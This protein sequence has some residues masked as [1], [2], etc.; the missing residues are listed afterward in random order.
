M[1]QLRAASAFWVLCAA[2]LAFAAAP[3]AATSAAT[4]VVSTSAV[5]NGSGNPD[6]E[7]TTGWFR[8]STISPG[9]CNDTFGT[10]VPATSGTG[11][12]TG[13]ATVTYAITASSLTAGTTY[14]FCAIT[15]NGSG[16]AFG[17][18][19]SFTTPGAP[20]V[21]TTGATNIS[22]TNAQL[23]GSANPTAAT[24]TGWF[25][26]ATTD[27]GPAT[28]P[29]GRACRPAAPPTP[30]WGAEAHRSPTPST[31]TPSSG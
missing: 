2:R 5:L 15:S 18:V 24:T 25:R 31:P 11:L 4:S 29:S 3:T 10:R 22:A 20:T 30:T 12:G 27:P 17:G 14:F 23:N 16:T 13:N 6:G 26:F 9:T 8:L 1:P 19:L 7:A 28:T 21:T